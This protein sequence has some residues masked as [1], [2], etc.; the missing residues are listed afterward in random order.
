MRALLS[1]TGAAAVLA[2]TVMAAPAQATSTGGCPT[3]TGADWMLVPV[4]VVI[5][6]GDSTG[7]ASLDGNGDGLTCL[8]IFAT[9]ER[10]VFRDN[11]VQGG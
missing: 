8:R 6:T 1:T 3:G 5:G 9:V 11:T 2:A 7:I 4:S 10:G